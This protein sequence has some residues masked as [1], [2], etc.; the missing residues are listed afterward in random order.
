VI[1]THAKYRGLLAYALPVLLGGCPGAMA[2]G[3][4]AERP[5]IF[6][7]AYLVQVFG[8]LLF[9]FGCLFGL[10][11]LFKKFNGIPMIDRKSIQVV[12]SVK[13]G[14]REKI[15]LVNAG[16]QQLLLG[17]AAGSVRTLHVFDEPVGEQ[18]EQK[19]GR[20]AS[21]ASVLRT[22]TAAGEMR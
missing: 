10:A 14:S 18:P 11:F 9:V 2:A 20:Q 8:S 21:F 17:V 13:V 3:A 22:S 1:V 12:G 4:A 19:S 6:D 5:E 16:S 15:L 7:S